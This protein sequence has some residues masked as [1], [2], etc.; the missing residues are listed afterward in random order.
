MACFHNAEFAVGW[1]K[2][3]A[4][5]PSAR[6]QEKEIGGTALRLSHPTVWDPKLGA[7]EVKRAPLTI[8]YELPGTSAE[9]KLKGL[10]PY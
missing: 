2:R 9:K 8:E 5:P 4:V 1:D 6:R 10:Y 3:S 7:V